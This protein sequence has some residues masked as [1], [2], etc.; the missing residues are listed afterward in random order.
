MNSIL[1]LLKSIPIVGW[2]IGGV[3]VL[4]GV[5]FVINKKGLGGSSSG[6]SVDSILGNLRNNRGRTERAGD[7]N[8]DAAESV[9]NAGDRIDESKRIVDAASDTID[10][11]EEQ[12]DESQRVNESARSTVNSLSGGLGTNK[13]LLSRASDIIKRVRSR[14]STD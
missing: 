3:V 2:V 14:K 4:I 10:R 13:E 6:I 7:N 5:K 8:R 12:L 9:D 11:S 1:E